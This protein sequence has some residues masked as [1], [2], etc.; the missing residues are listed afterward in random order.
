VSDPKETYSITSPG[1]AGQ[2]LLA[3][4]R[5]TSLGGE[6]T[7]DAVS[8]LVKAGCRH[9]MIDMHDVTDVDPKGL[10]SLRAIRSQLKSRKVSI[11]VINAD[12]PHLWMLRL[13]T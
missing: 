1:G 4:G 2:P 5:L 3:R 9:I 10:A 6:L 12:A 13:F 7:Y 11:Q 8:V